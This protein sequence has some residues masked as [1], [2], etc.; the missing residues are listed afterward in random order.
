VVIALIIGTAY[1]I[2]SNFFSN[3]LKQNVKVEAGSKL[4]IKDFID[5]K[6]KVTIKKGLTE[7]QS[8]TLGKHTVT[9]TVKGKDYDA[10]V[11]VVDTTKP[12]ITGVKKWHVDLKSKNDFT[13]GVTVKDNANGKTNL[14]VNTKKLNLKKEG[15]YTITYTAKDASGNTAK[16]STIVQVSDFAKIAKEKVVYLTFDDGPSYNTPKILKIL[17][18]YNATATFFVTAQ[19]PEYFKYI[20][21]AYKQGC[22]IGAHSYTH[23]FS[24]YRSEKTYFDDLAKIEEVIKKYTGKYSQDIRFPGGSSNT[25]SRH[26]ATGIMKK[27]SQD[28]EKRGYVYVDWNLDS[29]DASGNNVPVARLVANGT[30]T[31][32]NNLCILMHDTGAKKTTVKALPSII[33][34][35]KK[36]GYKFA[37]LENAPHVYHQRINN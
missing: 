28:V 21:A 14:K 19:W 37:T 32:S 5:T 22:Y 13:K 26:Y 35:Y 10:T 31:Y 9:L 25:V 8:R 29:T 6:Y 33:K 12:E 4:N 20:T 3:P 24:I 15:K 16:K 27:L 34:Y 7:K 17:K 2:Y 30:S 36:H 23:K 11:D 18:K 1:V